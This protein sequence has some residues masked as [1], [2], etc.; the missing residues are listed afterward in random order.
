MFTENPCDIKLECL[1]QQS[2]LNNRKKIKIKWEYK[3][4]KHSN[5]QNMKTLVRYS[6][7]ST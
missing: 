3:I 4:V 5:I 7:I 1:T 2:T 6:K